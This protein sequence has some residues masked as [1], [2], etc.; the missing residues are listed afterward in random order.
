MSTVLELFNTVRAN[1]LGLGRSELTLNSLISSAISKMLAFSKEFPIEVL[2]ELGLKYNIRTPEVLDFLKEHETL[3]S[4]LIEDAYN[5]IREYFPTEEL[6]L[7]I[8]T[9]PETNEKILVVFIRTDLN[10]EQALSKLEKLDEDWWLSA[11]SRAEKLCIHIEF[12]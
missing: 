12:V 5:K 10:P 4:F 8:L 1:I 6:V 2:T 7:D 3:A 11:A 9:D